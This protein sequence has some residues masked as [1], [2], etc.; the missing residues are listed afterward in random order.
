MCTNSHTWWRMR[1]DGGALP[2]GLRL[3]EDGGTLPLGLRLHE[4]LLD[5]DPGLLERRCGLPRSG[6]GVDS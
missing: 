4:D 6:G 3:R 5:H 2:L 1:K